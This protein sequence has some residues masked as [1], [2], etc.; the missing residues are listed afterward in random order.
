M[1]LAIRDIE[2]FR[3]VARSGLISS[4]ALELGLT[5]P[6]LTKAVQR[7]EEE[8]GTRLFERSATGV[9]LNSAGLRVAGQ[10]G[11]LQAQ[12]ADAMLLAGDMRANRAGLIRVGVT[13]ITAGNR[14]STALASMLAHRPGL[15]VRVR[16]DRS[17]ALAAQLRDGELDLALVPAYAG[18][19][20]QAQV[21]CVAQDPMLAVVRAD[22]PL[23]RLKRPTL[24]DV[25]RF[26]W[27]MGGEQSAAYQVLRQL[28]QSRQLPAPTIMV[29]VPFASDFS[30][31]LLA[32]TDLLTLV[33][34]SFS[35]HM[36]RQ[37]FAL[38]PIRE[39]ELERSVVLLSRLGG[40]WSPLM[41]ALR[42]ALLRQAEEGPLH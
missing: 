13:D 15:R 6:A 19:D 5:Q 40:S 9:R 35:R 2:Y 37:R 3:A 20:L 34:R 21:L 11:R 26:G 27:V 42:D 16:V 25:A 38:L 17:D 10:L 7:V 8:F 30:L 18:Q 41:E 28:F 12:Y 39:L 31:S 24:A 36:D 32:S 29:E 1:P 22:H 23:A 4:T 14:L 33:P